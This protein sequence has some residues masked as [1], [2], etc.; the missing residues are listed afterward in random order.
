MERGG[1]ANC[2][3]GHGQTKTRRDGVGGH[4]LPLPDRPPA[5]RPVPGADLRRAE[6]RAAARRRH[7]GGRARAR[8]SAGQ[9]QGDPRSDQARVSIRTC[10]VFFTF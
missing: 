3:R 6:V 10:V 2:G 9:V 1:V 4:R 5:A 7:A 8:I